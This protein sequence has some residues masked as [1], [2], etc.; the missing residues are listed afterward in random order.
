VELRR[1]GGLLMQQPDP[2]KVQSLF[3]TS[4]YLI[5]IDKNDNAS[6]SKKS[7]HKTRG[8]LLT[9]IFLGSYRTVP[10]NLKN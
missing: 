1:I 2:D 3:P 6:T 10:T 8:V 4:G 9:I 7:A 5:D